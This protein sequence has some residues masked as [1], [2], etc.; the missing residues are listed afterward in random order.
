MTTQL[1]GGAVVLLVVLG[2]FALL[3]MAGR[4]R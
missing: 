3:S 1:L 2:L 4:G